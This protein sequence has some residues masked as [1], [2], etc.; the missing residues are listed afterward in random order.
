MKE[1]LKQFI[2]ENDLNFN[3]SGSSLNGNCV[4]ISGYAL[5]IGA[6]Y[7]EMLESIDEMFPEADYYDEIL[8]VYT[9]AV[10]NNYGKYW[11]TEDAKKRYKF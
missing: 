9:Y 5:F 8:R 4:V 7:D 3:G 6:E 10:D 1:K 11:S 2:K